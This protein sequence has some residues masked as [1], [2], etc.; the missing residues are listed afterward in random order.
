M[1][2]IE[3]P[4]DSLETFVSKFLRL[5]SASGIILMLA[6]VL[7][8]I[9]ANSPLQ[10]FYNLLLDTPVV[11]AVEGFDGRE[12]L[13]EG[14]KPDADQ[15]EERELRDDNKPAYPESSLSVP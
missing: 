12:G 9:F 10:P 5:E 11:A 3:Q 14:K 6:A 8:L 7:A 15:E 4:V 1:S 13:V 2:K